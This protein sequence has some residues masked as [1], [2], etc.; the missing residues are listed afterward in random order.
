MGTKEREEGRQRG[1]AHNRLRFPGAEIALAAAVTTTATDRHLIFRVPLKTCNVLRTSQAQYYN[2][3]S[4]QKFFHE[5]R[6]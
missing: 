1:R 5:L 6:C 4:L 2:I 3:V